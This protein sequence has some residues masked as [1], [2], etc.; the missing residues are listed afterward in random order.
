MAQSLSQV[1]RG[2]EIVETHHNI[3]DSGKGGTV[4]SLTTK[5]ST[6]TA[7]EQVAGDIDALPLGPGSKEDRASDP[8]LGADLGGGLVTLLSLG[9]TG[10]EFRDT[11]TVAELEAIIAAE[12]ASSGVVDGSATGERVLR[13]SATVLGV[14]KLMG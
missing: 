6:S 3:V 14:A 11:L 8:R 10:L 4:D 13:V 2:P 5:R 1:A 9:G 12:V 7:R